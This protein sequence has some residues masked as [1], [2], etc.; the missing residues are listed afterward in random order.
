MFEG[1][2]HRDKI[3]LGSVI[4]RVFLKRVK[5][6]DET[7]ERKKTFRLPEKERKR[8]EYLLSRIKEGSELSLVGDSVE[9]IERPENSKGNRKR[10]LEPNKKETNTV[11]SK[12]K[13]RKRVVDVKKFVDKKNPNWRL[14]DNPDIQV[15]E[16]DPLFETKEKVPFV[17]SLAHSKLAIRAV[18]VN[19]MKLLE[20]V[21]N[22]NTKVYSPLIKRSLGNN[23]S[24][25]GYALKTENLEAVR[26]L[27]KSRT[28]NVRVDLP[29]CSLATTNTGTY[30][31]R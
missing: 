6:D 18:L 28:K 20:Q 25:L 23:M 12:V 14:K 3:S 30:N 2:E 5:E 17:S 16:K 9:L 29:T 26:I 27:L 31:Y 7:R 4:S 11:S 1:S 15:W 22:D 8:I 10:K 19:D 13:R 21:V 24:A